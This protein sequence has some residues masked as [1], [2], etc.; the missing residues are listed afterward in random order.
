[1]LY[2]QKRSN[3]LQLHLLPTIQITYSNPSDIHFHIIISELLTDYK[4]N[5]IN[6][7]ALEQKAIWTYTSPQVPMPPS[8][9]QRE[10]INPTVQLVHIESTRAQLS[11]IVQGDYR[12]VTK[13]WGEIIHYIPPSLRSLIQQGHIL[14]NTVNFPSHFYLIK[15][16]LKIKLFDSELR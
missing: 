1:M 8:N 10:P 14:I 4:K 2:F 16:N 6:Q 15:S 7:K 9:A 5:E 12:L 13:S 3:I 11:M